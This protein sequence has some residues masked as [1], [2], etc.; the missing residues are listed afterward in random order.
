MNS[1]VTLIDVRKEAMDT[2][3][4]LR[5]KTIDAKT[6]NEIRNLL[7][8]VIDTAKVQIDFIK[9][10]PNSIKDKMTIEEI[11][12]FIGKKEEEQTIEETLA[13][14]EA[15]RKSTYSIDRPYTP[16]IE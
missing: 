13:E 7:N 8:T 3:N 2:I 14:I 12:S 15:K 11:G 9:V 5:S 1:E 4:Q 16:H 6:A 10:L